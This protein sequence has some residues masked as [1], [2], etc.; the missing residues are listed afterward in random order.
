MKIYCNVLR[1]LLIEELYPALAAGFIYNIFVD[2]EGIII[3]L[4]GFN[5]KLPVNIHSNHIYIVY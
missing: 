5:E 4:D 3:K 1:M 2:E